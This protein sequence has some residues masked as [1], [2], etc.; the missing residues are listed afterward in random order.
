MV[1][2]G[3]EKATYSNKIS[4]MKFKQLINN[5]E[6]CS[7]Q[8]M[9]EYQ[10]RLQPRH[11]HSVLHLLPFMLLALFLDSAVWVIP[12]QLQEVIALSRRIIVT[13]VIQTMKTTIKL[14]TFGRVG[15]SCSH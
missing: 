2:K 1:L 4:K 10:G 6:E 7:G 5:K 13:M 11:G 14:T 9:W 3:C 8:A 12:K 15:G